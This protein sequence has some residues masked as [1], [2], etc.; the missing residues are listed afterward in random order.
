MTERELA[1]LVAAWQHR[2]GLDGWVIRV[3]LA[4][5][6][7]DDAWAEV[8]TADHYDLAT[9]RVARWFVAGDEPPSKEHAQLSSD[10]RATAIEAVV[11][12][13]LLH[14]ALRSQ[15]HVAVD[16]LSGQLHRDVA[17]VHEKTYD[18][19]AERE[20]DGLAR[21]L[22]AAWHAETAPRRRS[23]GSRAAPRR[24]RPQT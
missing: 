21:A 2:L 6:G 1:R 13:E 24:T 16:L 9:V 20:I 14:V 5:F 10:D 8:R 19:A 23:H 4:D 11:V 22:V 7:A 3:E 18:A 17:T 15:R 12:H